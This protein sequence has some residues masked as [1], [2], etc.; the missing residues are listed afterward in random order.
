MPLKPINILLVRIRRKVIMLFLHLVVCKCVWIVVPFENL[1]KVRLTLRAYY[2]V[3]V[4]VPFIF[5][6]M[7]EDQLPRWGLR[8]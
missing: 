1:C 6:L 3:L 8:A 5:A 7:T 2:T 4:S